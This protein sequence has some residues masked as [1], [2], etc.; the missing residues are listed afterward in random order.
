MTSTRARRRRPEPVPVF[1]MPA[2]LQQAW[3][4]GASAATFATSAQPFVAAPTADPFP[5][6]WF[7]AFLESVLSYLA[8]GAP[9]RA[10]PEH[11]RAHR[12]VQALWPQ[13]PPGLRTCMERS[14]FLLR[15]PVLPQEPA[16]AR[17]STTR[18]LQVL[19]LAH[20]IHALVAPT[21]VHPSTQLYYARLVLHESLFHST[22]GS[23]LAQQALRYLRL[24]APR[25]LPADL[26]HLLAPTYVQKG[27]L[28]HA[29]ALL[30]PAA[31]T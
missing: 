21:C 10:Y 30:P 6:M 3:H 14:G 31:H 17:D 28:L 1:A 8:C 4:E 27:L 15:R 13:L 2:V 9:K 5:A 16:A 25:L 11:Q 22:A 20:R 24:V 23:P 26:R 19:R 18:P 7:E 12:I 29:R